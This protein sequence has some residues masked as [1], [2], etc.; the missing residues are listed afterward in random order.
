MIGNEQFDVVTVTLNPA[1]DQTL[2]VPEFSAGSVNRAVETRSNAGGKGV[3]VAAVLAD[4]GCRVAATGFLGR[5]NT[6]PFDSLLLSRG[7]VNAFVTTPGSTRVGIKIV[8]P[9]TSETTDINLPGQ[10]VPCDD[11]SAF[12]D[13]LLAIDAKW[14]VLAGSLPPGVPATIYRDLAVELRARGRRVALDTS[15]EAL[16]LA[17]EA[18]VDVVKPNIAELS[19]IL[20]IKIN[21]ASEIVDAARTLIGRG[22]RLA[23]VSLGAEGAWFVTRDDA[24][25]ASPSPVDVAS[26][27]G[28]GDAMVAGV[29]AASLEGLGLDECARLATAFSAEAVT[30][31]G[32]GLTSR[33]RSEA[34]AADVRLDRLTRA[35]SL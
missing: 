26:T 31:V 34:L 32:A 15:G 6:G 10:A 8:D 33:A 13:R 35:A 19:E 14:V 18:G 21:S 5:E 28:A 9:V 7:I 2:T 3:N 27:V 24:V 16:S 1:I 25:H 23:V 17:V 20:G 30:R 11:M 22:V 12:R 4:Y 29:V